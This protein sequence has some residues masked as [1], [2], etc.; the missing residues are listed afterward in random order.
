MRMD[1]ILARLINRPLLMDRSYARTLFSSLAGKMNIASLIDSQGEVALGEKV[2]MKAGLFDSKSERYRPYRVVD[3]IAVVPIV[4]SLLHR[5]PYL[6][7]WVTGY[8]GVI[9]V[10]ELAVDDPDVDAILLDIDSPGGEV[11]G[12]FDAA[13]RLRELGEQKP[14]GSLCNDMTLS[15]AMCLASAA[16]HRLITS[17]GEAGSV[18]VVMAHWDYSEALQGEGIAVTLIY[19]GEHKIDGNAYQALPD[20][21]YSRFSAECLELRREFAAIVAEHTGV[22]VDD[23]LATEAATYRG[24]AAIDVGFADELVNSHDAISAFRNY[25]SPGD[26]QSTGTAMKN[27]QSNAAARAA[28]NA[29]SATGEQQE[30]V[31]PA[32]EVEQATAGES[33]ATSERERINQILGCA[34][35]AGREQLARH[36]ALKTDLSPE[37]CAGILEESPVADTLESTEAPGSALSQAMQPHASSG[38][39]A[40]GDGEDAGTETDSKAVASRIAGNYS[41]MTGRGK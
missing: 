6:S 37:A 19:S 12:C 38:V 33:A 20:D 24:Q 7:P 14:I 2:R 40:G 27:D 26:G 15:A 16:Q 23:V 28:E 35:A 4:G 10:V 34:Q 31:Q 3:G 5:F 22:S 11:S 21:V 32:A 18:G 17:T 41:R 1:Q 39:T 13:K 25:L 29:A 9:R 36:L 30:Q 8:D